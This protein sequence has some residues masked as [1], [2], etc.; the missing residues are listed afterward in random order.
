MA[1]AQRVVGHEAGNDSREEILRAAA[2]LFMEFGYVATS[3]DAVAQRLGATKGRIYHYYRSKSDLFFDVQI[4]AMT[5]LNEAVEPIARGEGGPIA[6][7]AAM[8]L[9]HTQI[10][11]TELPMQKVAVQ[12][13]ERHLLA[14]SDARQLRA[15]VKMR[16]HYE[17]LFVEVI[18]EGIRAGVFVDLPPKLATKPF[19]GAMNW[20]TVWYS[21]RRLQS[22]DAIDDIARSLAAFA[23]RGILKDVGHE[24]ARRTALLGDQRS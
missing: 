17:D 7:L 10:L 14:S 23:M 9:R 15:V 22:A 2:E 19:F 4:A 24:E 3:I 11:L 5:R 8:A 1:T 21:Q 6:R 12:G 18:D 16:D 20:A 13:L